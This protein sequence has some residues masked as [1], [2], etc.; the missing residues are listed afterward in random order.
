MLYYLLYRAA[1]GVCSKRGKKNR[2]G[3]T[4]NIAP[5]RTDACFCCCVSAAR[6]CTSASPLTPPPLVVSTLVARCCAQARPTLNAAPIARRY[7]S[8]RCPPSIQ[9]PL[10][11]APVIPRRHRITA[12]LPHPILQPSS[13]CVIMLYPS[14]TERA[15]AHR[16][17]PPPRAPT[18][19]LC[20]LRTPYLYPLLEVKE[21]EEMIM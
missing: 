12:L 4:A 20:I 17:P 9:R 3:P 1:G 14:K 19:R 21:G 6:R 16:I 18:I 15:R 10:V 7:T 2:V 8:A 5:Q 11:T 13:H